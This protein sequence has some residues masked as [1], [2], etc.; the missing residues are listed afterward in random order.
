AWYLSSVE[1]LPACTQNRFHARVV[2]TAARSR[3][4]TTPGART[5]RTPGSAAP[6]FTH[7]P[8]RYPGRTSPWCDRRCI[9]Y[10]AIGGMD[11]SVPAHNFSLRHPQYA[12]FR[13]C[14]LDVRHELVHGV[15]QR[16]RCSRHLERTLSRARY[17]DCA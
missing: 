3:R 16:A 6:G 5:D 8:R 17:A 7:G 9:R 2:D 12:P 11:G 14:T 13:C 4:G 1:L 15:A 10:P